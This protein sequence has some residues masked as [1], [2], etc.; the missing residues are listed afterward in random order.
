MTR[1]SARIAVLCLG[2]LATL[3]SIAG[4][5][6]PTQG[7]VSGSVVV[8]GEPAETGAISFIPVS[9]RGTTAGAVIEQG[10]YKATVPV[11]EVRIEVR[12]P[13]VVGEQK[14]YDTPDS[15]V[16]QVMEESLPARFNA[17]SELTWE[18]PSGKSTRDF[19]FQTA[20]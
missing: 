12:V 15:P 3:H 5:S 19:D 13:K 17:Q 20:E 10:K 16:Q 11:G 2:T 4:C 1:R 8:D 9:G 7:I 14:I 18:V 6:D